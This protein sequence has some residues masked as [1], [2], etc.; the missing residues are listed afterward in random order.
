MF[1]RLSQKVNLCTM[2]GSVRNFSSENRMMRAITVDPNLK[3]AAADELR[4]GEVPIP[5]VNSDTEFL[6]K[7]EATAV[8]RADILQR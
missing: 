6:I 3:N 7:V 1:A 8:N 4:I 5:E 2:K